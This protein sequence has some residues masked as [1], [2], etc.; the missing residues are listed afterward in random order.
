MRIYNELTNFNSRAH[1]RR[2]SAIRLVVFILLEFQLTRPRKARRFFFFQ[3]V[4]TFQFQLTRPRKA[5]LPPPALVIIS[6]TFQLTRP[7]K[8]RRFVSFGIL[9]SLLF[10]LTRPRKARPKTGKFIC[11]DSN[12][13][14]RAHARRD[15]GLDIVWL[16]VPIS[17]HAPTQGATTLLFCLIVLSKF[18]LTRPRKARRQGLDFVWLFVPNFNSRAH[19]RRDVGFLY[20]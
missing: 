14:S 9:K 20:F 1:A 12:F 5:R 3:S 6:F 4:K 13:N 11:L 7:R 15:Q 2:D 16:F 17:T 8:A 18:Q 19:A 10:Q